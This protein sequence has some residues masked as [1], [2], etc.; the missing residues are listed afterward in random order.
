MFTVLVNTTHHTQGPHAA[1]SGRLRTIGEIFYETR[2]LRGRRWSMRRFTQE[3]LDGRIEPVMLSYIE[4]GERFPNEDL[5]RHLAAFC[6]EEPKQL[7]AVLWRERML[8][9]IGRELDRALQAEPEVGGAEDGALAVRLSRAM[10][11]LPDDGAWIPYKRWR[12]EFRDGGKRRRRTASEEAALDAQVEESLR[13]H[14]LVE[15]RGG[16]VRRK[17]RHLQ[18]EGVEERRAVARQF[19]ELFAKGLLDR[20]ALKD[21]D[22]GTYLRNHYANIERT[23]IREFHEALEAAL[24]TLTERFAVTPSRETAFMNV[25]TTATLG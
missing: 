6:G 23:R 20:V 1:E 14:A 7:L 3:A 19:A 10:A 13:R 9:A 18:A 17:G 16:R 21:A 2:V 15:I 12:R 4:K 22:T 8:Q 5:V 24:R 11:L 25:L